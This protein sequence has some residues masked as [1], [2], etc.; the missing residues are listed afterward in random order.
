MRA[1]AASAENKNRFVT[2]V[3]VSNSPCTA[4]NK[5]VREIHDISAQISGFFLRSFQ[6]SSFLFL[7]AYVIINASCRKRSPHFDMEL[8]DFWR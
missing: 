8:L 7:P 5:R 3:R 4:E 6:K 2:R 1:F